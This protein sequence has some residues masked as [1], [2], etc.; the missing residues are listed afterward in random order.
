MLNINWNKYNIKNNLNVV[1]LLFYKEIKKTYRDK[2]TTKLLKLTK[3]KMI[4]ENLKI[5][6]FNLLIKIIIR[7]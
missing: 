7:Y 6:T 4:M 1:Y 3:I 2:N 5:K